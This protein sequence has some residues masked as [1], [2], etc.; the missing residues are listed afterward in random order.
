MKILTLILSIL[1]IILIG[2]NVT[3]INFSA[4]FENESMVAIITI[5]ASLCAIILLQILT[6]SKKIE[7]KFKTKN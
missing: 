7:Q 5:F 3:K 2:F 1:A 6:V 4:P